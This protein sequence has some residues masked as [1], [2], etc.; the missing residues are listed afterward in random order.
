MRPSDQREQR[1]R[2]GVDDGP[3]EYTKTV[4]ASEE[5]DGH[6]DYNNDNRGVG[7]G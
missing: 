4:E 7:G 5:E 2:R 6:K 1:R 3:E